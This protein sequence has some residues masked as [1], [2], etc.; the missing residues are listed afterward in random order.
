MRLWVGTLGV[1]VS[2][3]L[4]SV[5]VGHAAASASPQSLPSAGWVLAQALGAEL[6]LPVRYSESIMQWLPDGR[7][8]VTTREV[9]QV[10][11]LRR[12]V[13]E[14]RR[15]LNLVE[16][17]TG[18]TAW[19]TGSAYVLHSS[20]TSLLLRMQILET[21]G[22]P[23]P[24]SLLAGRLSAGSWQSQ[25][26]GAEFSGR[27]VYQV[28]LSSGAG[29]S[30]VRYLLWVDQ[31]NG[32]LWRAEQYGGENQLLVLVVR[33]GVTVPPTQALALSKPSGSGQVVLQRLDQWAQ[34]TLSA[35]LLRQLG[36]GGTLVPWNL[37]SSYRWL[38]VQTVA[39]DRPAERV[40]VIRLQTGA[41][42]VSIYQQKMDM[43]SGSSQVGPTL[44]VP[45]QSDLFSSDSRGWLGLG[46]KSLP[47][48]ATVSEWWSE[49]W[50][51]LPQTIHQIAVAGFLV[52][53][54]GDLD[55]NAVR[56]LTRSLQPLS[57]RLL[58]L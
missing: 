20:S 26:R 41:G 43:N 58:G 2:I 37:P 34:L 18:T 51:Q 46:G 24:L 25:V 27:P 39:G 3:A 28:D 15:T 13:Q 23:L 44:P 1:V 29:S 22:V 55:D 21:G 12:M 57:R 10:P 11:P 45:P 54:V 19:V 30:A 56:Q 48:Q 40:V 50:S 8:E 49:V 38:D 5:I 42:I 53:L 14:G 31:A 32:F 16:D 36:E 4:D 17:S 35:E 6:N 33:S 52:T 7:W 9:W 47:N